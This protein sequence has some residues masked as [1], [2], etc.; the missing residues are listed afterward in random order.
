M[1][2]DQSH[3]LII[4]SCRTENGK[5]IRMESMRIDVWSYFSSNIRQS[6]IAEVE[7]WRERGESLAHCA[8]SA[9]TERMGV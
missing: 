3:Y 2:S 4:D 8:D 7:S 5:G 6:N 1:G 9:I